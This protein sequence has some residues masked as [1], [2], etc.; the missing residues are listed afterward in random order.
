MKQT[1]PSGLGDRSVVKQAGVYL[2]G[3]ATIAAGILDLIWREFDAAHQPIG[4]FGNHIPGHVIFADMIA[5]W[6]IVAGAAVLWRR[7]ARAGALAM[8]I[9]Y[10]VFGMF[11]LPLFYTVPHRFGFRFTVFLGVLEVTFMQLILVAGGLILYASFAPPGSSWPQK[12]SIVARWTFG[13]GSVLFG[14]G[15]L[16]S[17]QVVTPMIPKWMPLGASFWVVFS[18]IGFLLAG[19]AILSGLLNLLAARLL[20]L[21]LLIFEVALVPLVLAHPHVHVVWG[22]NAYNLVVVGAVWIFAASIPSPHV[23]R[24]YD[25]K[26]QFAE[27]S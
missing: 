19:L 14:L 16:I 2:Y 13:L 4:G 18:G 25:A 10:L 21:M 15:H 5:V 20:V 9:T 8:A 17:G 11:C 6:M 24:E 1:L 12:S 3:L 26:P 23:R 7:A 27:V 22:S